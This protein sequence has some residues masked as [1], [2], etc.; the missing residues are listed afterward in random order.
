MCASCTA[1]SLSHADVCAISIVSMCDALLKTLQT[2][3]MQLV[4]MRLETLLSEPTMGRC[5]NSQPSISS[6]YVIIAAQ[7]NNA[8]SRRCASWHHSSQSSSSFAQATAELEAGQ[9][10]HAGLHGR[11][12][13]VPEAVGRSNCAAY[14]RVGPHCKSQQN[15]P[16]PSVRSATPAAAL[17]KQL[18]QQAAARNPQPPASPSSPVDGRRAESIIERTATHGNMSEAE[19]LSRLQVSKRLCLNARIGLRY[20]AMGR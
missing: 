3:D 6:L 17:R 9:M 11:R 15:T 2:G 5:V 18:Q 7:A 19:V 20:C 4:G 8:A 16:S 10:R 12:S 1:I 13:E 14:R